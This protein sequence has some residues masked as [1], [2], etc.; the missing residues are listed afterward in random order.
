VRRLI[1]TERREI[2][3]YREREWEKVGETDTQD[4]K[5]IRKTEKE[6]RQGDKQN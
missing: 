2:R 4:N 3:I 1:K 6:R 5:E